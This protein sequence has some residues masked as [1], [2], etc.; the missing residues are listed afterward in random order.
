MTRG[1]VSTSSFPQ[2]RQIFVTGRTSQSM[3]LPV[4]IYHGSLGKIINSRALIDSGAT[5]CFID[6][7]FVIKNNW[8]KE[9]L[10]SPILAHNADGSPNQ[11]GMIHFQTRLTLHIGEKEEQ[12]WFYLL[13]LGNEN[14]ILGLPWL[15]KTNPVINWTTGK[16]HLPQERKVPQHDS[17]DAQYQR[18]LV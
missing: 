7:E 18:Y 11:K 8:P 15:H 9:Q 1:D 16:V 5:G 2:L 4:S 12:Q 10:A 17:P 13:H 6:H 3:R 14:M